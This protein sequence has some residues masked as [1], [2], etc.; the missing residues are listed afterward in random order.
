MAATL[1]IGTR[2]GKVY[3]KNTPAKLDAVPYITG[4][5]PLGSTLESERSMLQMTVTKESVELDTSVSVPGKMASLKEEKGDNESTSSEEMEV[6]NS[7]DAADLTEPDSETKDE[8]GDSDS[9][10]DDSVSDKEVVFQQDGRDHVEGMEELE[11]DVQNVQLP[12]GMD[13]PT[14]CDPVL[15]KQVSAMVAAEF[16]KGIMTKLNNIETILSAKNTGL[17]G[18]T[19]TLEATTKHLYQ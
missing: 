16:S 5:K 6:D 2:S 1:G 19:K 11:G 18:R 10:N 13:P 17:V 9:D 15:L 8:D 12:T 3:S 7:R 4:E 14:G